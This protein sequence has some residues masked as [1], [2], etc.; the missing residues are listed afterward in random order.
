MAVIFHASCFSPAVFFQRRCV[1]IHLRLEGT[2]VMNCD[3]LYHSLWDWSIIMVATCACCRASG[4]R[5]T[6]PHAAGSESLQSAGKQS[7]AAL[8]GWN[9]WRNRG[10]ANVSTMRTDGKDLQLWNLR[11]QT[12]QP[13]YLCVRLEPRWHRDTSATPSSLPICEAGALLTLGHTCYPFSYRCLVAI[14]KIWRILKEMFVFAE[15]WGHLVNPSTA[16]FPRCV[17]A[18]HWR[19]S[20]CHTQFTSK[21]KDRVGVFLSTSTSFIFKDKH[22]TSFGFTWFQYCIE[23][24]GGRPMWT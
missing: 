17:P 5:W 1:C 10:L 14:R 12:V 9:K 16:L 11:L 15:I 24:R 7:P 21:L 8:M 18:L 20:F 23:Y 13:A 22:V 3:R 4:E 19:Q 2:T 6:G